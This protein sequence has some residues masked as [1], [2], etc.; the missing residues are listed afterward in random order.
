MPQDVFWLE[1]Y[2]HFELLG[3]ATRLEII[4][5]LM[6]P[7][8]VAE[9]AERMNVPRLYHHVNL[10]EQAGLIRVVDT[11]QSGVQM[12]KIYQAAARN[13]R[14]SKEFMRTALPRDKAQAIIKSLLGSTQAD[15][16]HSVESGA[17]LLEDPAEARQTHF[18]RNLLRLTPD[19]LHAFI[20]EL[21]G[22][23]ERYD[24]PPL[25]EA[26]ASSD[27]KVIGVVSL[28]YPSSRSIP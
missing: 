20:L 12:E 14:P 1:S 2:E 13:F 22:L 7:A 8:T 26:E 25:P 27:L 11:R 6:A 16:I 18:A 21:E 4:E 10:L 24:T 15:F 9:L 17:A 5:L 28:V 23:I 19:R 3:D